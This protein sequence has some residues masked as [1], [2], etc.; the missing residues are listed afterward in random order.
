MSDEKAIR[1]LKREKAFWQ[2]VS[3]VLMVKTGIINRQFV[4]EQIMS[5][6][7]EIEQEMALKL[8]KKWL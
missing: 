4:E 3:M 6:D 8:S 7:L 5:I 2:K 1:K